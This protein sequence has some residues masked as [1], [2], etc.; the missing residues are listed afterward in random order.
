M[1][2]YKN[3]KNFYEHVYSF[4]NENK[5]A[6]WLFYSKHFKSSSRHLSLLVIKERKRFK[7]IRRKLQKSIVVRALKNIEW[8]YFVKK[9]YFEY[10]YI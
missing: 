5:I 9:R 6:P 8:G 7:E 1:E 3:N 2:K 4:P 10:A